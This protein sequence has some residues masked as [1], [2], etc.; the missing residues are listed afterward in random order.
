[1]PSPITTTLTAGLLASTAVLAGPVPNTKRGF[2]ISQKIA[3][4]YVPPA[5]QMMKAFRKYNVDVPEDV[6]AAAAGDGSV[7]AVVSWMGELSVVT[8]GRTD[9]HLCLA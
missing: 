3:K 9:L 5:V 2:S 8:R 1:M 6:A 4:P 7:A